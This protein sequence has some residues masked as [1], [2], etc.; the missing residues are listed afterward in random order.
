MKKARKHGASDSTQLVA[1]SYLRLRIWNVIEA[2]EI[3]ML[4]ER[5]GDVATVI[6]STPRMMFT[7]MKSR[8]PSRALKLGVSL[9]LTLVAAM[10]AW[11]SIERLYTAY[12]FAQGRTP[13]DHLTQSHIN[14]VLEHI[15]NYSKQFKSGKSNRWPP[16]A[17]SAFV[18]CR[19]LS[20]PRLARI[21]AQDAAARSSP[22]NGTT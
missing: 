21:A 7:N 1:A 17:D 18:R 14:G 16:S 4:D 5:Y 15:C 12:L 11:R 6:R 20:D 3:K 19:R 10:M 2:L 9:P 22:T 8:T 13:T